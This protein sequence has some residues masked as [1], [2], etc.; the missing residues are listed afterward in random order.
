MKFLRILLYI[1]LFLVALKVIFLVGWILKIGIIL[2]LIGVVIWFF[3]S[4]FKNG[5]D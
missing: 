3:S 1:I 5:Q 2:L 4:I